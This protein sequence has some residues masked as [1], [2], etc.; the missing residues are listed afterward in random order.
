MIR[1]KSKI[2]TSTVI[3]AP[4]CQKCFQDYEDNMKLF[5]ELL[6]FRI[7]MSQTCFGNPY[8]LLA[9]PKNFYCQKIWHQKWYK[10]RQNDTCHSSRERIYEFN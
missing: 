10:Q 7:P 3:L 4:N 1:G 5:A 8:L 6:C 2:S 9:S